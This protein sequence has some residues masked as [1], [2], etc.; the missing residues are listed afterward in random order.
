LQGK[1]LQT[2][3]SEFL[4]IN[5]ETTIRDVYVKAR[6][7]NKIEIHEREKG[8]RKRRK[9]KEKIGRIHEGKKGKIKRE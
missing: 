2:A 7:K 5:Q 3:Y 6:K 1:I 8:R 9:E 4:P